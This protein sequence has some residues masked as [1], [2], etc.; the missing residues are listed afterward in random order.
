MPQ[1]DKIIEIMQDGNTHPDF[2]L[3]LSS[4]PHPKFPITLLQ[5]AIKVSSEQP[6]VN[7]F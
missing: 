4:K 1:L 2:K 6:K 3:W 5:T 7:K